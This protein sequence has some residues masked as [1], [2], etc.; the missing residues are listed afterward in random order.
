MRFGRQTPAANQTTV[1]AALAAVYIV[2][3]STYLALRFGLD[4][5]PPFILN[6]LRFLFAGGVMYPILRSRGVPPPTPRQWWNVA[7]VG[8]LLLVGGVGLVTIAE[9]QGVGSGVAATAVAVM[10]LWAALISGVFGKWPVPRE[11]AGLALGFVG[12]AVLAQEGDLQAS[13]LGLVLVLI[14]PVMWAFGSVWGSRLDLPAPM[15]TAA[16]QL[17]VGGSALILLGP[18]RGERINEAPQVG[19]WV[20]LAYLSILGSIVAYAAYIYLLDSVRPAL[21][22]SYAYVNPVVAVFLGLTLGREAVTGAAWIALPIVLV[23]VI[24]VVTAR[25]RQPDVVVCS[26]VV[27]E[28]RA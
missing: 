25:Q 4:G 26:S 24:L 23:G 28:E 18:M 17:L 27:V 6:G 19:A 10:P 13:S 21:A 1:I 15:M 2:W 12:V 8:L 20:A 3:G 22:T 14:A 16:A 9:D 7:R 5:F 11:W